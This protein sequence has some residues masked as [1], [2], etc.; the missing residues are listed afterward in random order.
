MQRLK[1]WINTHRGADVRKQHLV[2][3]C[4]KILPPVVCVDVGASYYPHPAWDLFR[5]SPRTSWVAIDP[6]ARNLAYLNPWGWPSRVT[7]V[8]EAVSRTGGPQTLY[9]THVDSGSS[10]LKPTTPNAAQHRIDPDYVYPI[11][12]RRLETRTLAAI[13]GPLRQGAPL[14]VKIDTQGT[15]LGILESLGD[16]TIRDEVVC[17]ETEASLS[18]CPLYEGAPTLAMIQTFMEARGFELA[19]LHVIDSR[20]PRANPGLQG[21]GVPVECDAVFTVR[22]DVL[23]RRSSDHQLATLGCYI[24]YQLF[25]EARHL[26][27]Q[28]QA[29]PPAG[30]NTDD[31]EW[32]QRLLS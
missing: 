30:V 25:G 8:E 24:A 2:H 29:K 9:V 12:E 18:A 16:Q 23:D 22:R 15:E 1:R 17:V 19:H 13:L 7:A 5:R 10:L 3:M 4:S 21:R 11:S 20:L 27:A 26:I 6:N 28:L 14:L 31:L 32:L